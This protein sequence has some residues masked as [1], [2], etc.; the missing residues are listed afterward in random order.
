MIASLSAADLDLID[1]QNGTDTPLTTRQWL[2]H[3]YGHL[4]YHLGQ[5]DYIRRVATGDG[6]IELAQL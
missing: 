1:P 6:A 5:I 2:I 3:L 4:S